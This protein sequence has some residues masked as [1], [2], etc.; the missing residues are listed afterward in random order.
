MEKRDR[1]MEM[2]NYEESREKLARGLA[3]HI[4][5]W[6]S[7]GSAADNLDGMILDIRSMLDIA[8]ALGMFRLVDKQLRLAIHEQTKLDLD[9]AQMRWFIARELDLRARF[10]PDSRD[11]Q[12]RD[13]RCDSTLEEQGLSF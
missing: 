7:D 11:T 9:R 8:D 10:K 12:A 13:D 4:L 3:L 6:A 5:G 1:V 2:L